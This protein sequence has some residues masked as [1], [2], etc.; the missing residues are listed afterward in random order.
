MT[1]A[2]KNNKKVIMFHFGVASNDNIGMKKE[3]NAHHFNGTWIAMEI[4]YSADQL[5]LIVYQKYGNEM[6]SNRQC[7]LWQKYRK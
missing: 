4:I 5:E 6:S 2:D 3:P 1:N 7:G